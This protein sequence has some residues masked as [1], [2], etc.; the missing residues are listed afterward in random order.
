MAE[1]ELHVT[2]I[3]EAGKDYAFE[4]SPAW[5]DAQLQDASLRHDPAYG[6]GQ[7][8]VH[9]QE[10]GV[11]EYLVTGTMRAHV[12]TECGRCLGD[13]KIAVD[14]AIATLYARTS[15]ARPSG[16]ARTGQER[17]V[18]TE[19]YERHADQKEDEDDDFPREE[20]SGNAIA[21]DEFVRE[22]IVLELPMQPLCGE[23]CTGIA[24]PAHLLPP[25]DVFPSSSGDAVDPR[26]APLQRLR[27]NV[28]PMSQPEAPLGT[29]ARKQPDR[30]P[31]PKPK[32]NK[33]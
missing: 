4:L 16:A 6:P 17:R 13:A 22:H 19:R 7:L 5:L 8:E 12:L 18:R 32:F 10:N 27:D 30:Q 14:V 29:P 23:A 24:I 2:D 26:L 25:A 1:F 28:P 15:A 21:L 9:A 11:G 20:F 3:D 33:E 31:Q